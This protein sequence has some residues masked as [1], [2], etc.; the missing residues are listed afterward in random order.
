MIW[1]NLRTWREGRVYA[2]VALAALVVRGILFADWLHSPLRYFHR[3]AGLD[4]MTLLR[5]GEWGGAGVVVFSPHRALV[6]LLWNLNGGTHPVA[7]LAVIQLLC[8]TAT[9]VLTAYAAFRLWGDRRAALASG[10]IAALFAPGAMYELTMLQ[11]TLVLFTF[12]AGFAGILWARKHHFRPRYGVAAGALL[13]L[14]SIGRPTA[15]LWVF[16]ALAWSG[17]LLWRRG[18]L[19]R[20]GALAGGVLAVWLV[21][22]A[23]NWFCAG[24]P[25]PFYHVLGYSAAVNA[26]PAEEGGETVVPAAA[27]AADSPAG[28]LLRIGSN[29][30]LRLPKVFL[31]HEIPDNMNYYFIREHVPAL[32]LLIGPGLLVPFAL[33]GLALT[34]IFGRFARREGVIL[35]AVFALAL[36]ICANYPVGRYRLILLTPF[37]LLAVE[38]FRLGLAKPRKV[39]LPVAAAVLAGAFLVNPPPDGRFFRSSDFVAWALALEQPSGQANPESLATLVEG[40]RFSGGE[41]VAMNLLIRLIGLREFDAAERLI[42]DALGRGKVNPSL[43]CYY[44]ALIKLERGDVPAAEALLGRVSPEQLGDLAVKYEFMLG[45]IARRKGELGEARRRFLRALA[46]PDPF[47][48]RPVIEN[49][50]RKLEAPASL[51]GQE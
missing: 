27:V 7:L 3:V 1:D 42:G 13:G 6:A 24:Y 26:A 23:L 12:T 5:F 33:A 18:R 35:L 9:A 37:A 32:K 17:F 25:G 14:A 30:V 43:L 11:E 22:G 47:G 19:K 28:K 49:A 31:A 38:A 44:G 39:R 36:P 29:A 34:V 16:A 21:T 10:L 8:G 46:G 40:Y 50:L 41:A 4:M 51:P 15:L 2:V 45:E 20:L 48:F